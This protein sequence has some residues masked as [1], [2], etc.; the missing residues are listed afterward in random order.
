[1]TLPWNCR[2]TIWDDSAR[3]LCRMTLWDNSARQLR[4][5]T[6]LIKVGC[7]RWIHQ[8]GCVEWLVGLAGWLPGG[9][10][11]WLY[12][13]TLP[14]GCVVWLYCGGLRWMILIVGLDSQM[15]GM[16]TELDCVGCL[17]QGCVGCL[18]VGWLC[19]RTQPG[20]LFSFLGPFKSIPDELNYK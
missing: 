18:Y 19:W 13:M 14:E 7:V 4:R 6:I 10:V 3:R 1:M 2:M 11:G 16:T 5:M 20:G 17:C 12:W 15:L 9:Y 8:V